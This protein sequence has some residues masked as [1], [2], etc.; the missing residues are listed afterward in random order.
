VRSLVAALLPL[1]AAGCV[2]TGASN[3]PEIPDELVRRG[4]QSMSLATLGGAEL[5]SVISTPPDGFSTCPSAVQDG[6]GW[7]FDYG[8][9]GCVPDSGL[10]TDTVLGLIEVTVA[11]GSGAFI[12]SFTEMGVGESLL[13]GSI[14]GDTSAA[15]D[16]LS[17]DLDLT[18]GTW[19]RGP[20]SFELSAFLEI[21]GDADSVGL[22]VDAGQLTGS[23]GPLSIDVDDAVIPRE[24]FVACTVPAEGGMTLLRDVDRADLTF[25]S[26]SHQSGNV[27]ANFSDRDPSTVTVCTD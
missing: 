3:D 10:T 27:T 22:F 8:L 26:D 1:V 9:E 24:G 14:S 18:G 20:A 25:S 7:T 12:G 11:E 17:V 19:L 4:V 6:D 21:T 23:E 16:L 2:N 13:S 15:G 5:G